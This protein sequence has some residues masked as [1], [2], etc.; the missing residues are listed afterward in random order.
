MHLP[1]HTTL[2][3]DTMDTVKYSSLKAKF[4][5]MEKIFHTASMV[6]MLIQ[7]K[8]NLKFCLSVHYSCF[9]CSKA[10]YAKE[11][12]FIICSYRVFSQ[13][14]VIHVHMKISGMEG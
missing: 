7:L 13:N 6:N 4:C 11:T 9:K 3:Y 1:K 12:T 14:Y 10:I 8:S 2:K 5:S